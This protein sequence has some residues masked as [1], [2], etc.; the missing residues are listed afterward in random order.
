MKNRHK[1]FKIP[2]LGNRNNRPQ[3]EIQKGTRFWNEQVLTDPI[4]FFFL[5]VC[6][7]RCKP[8]NISRIKIIQSHTKL[9]KEPNKISN[10][11]KFNNKNQILNLISEFDNRFDTTE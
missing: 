7:K 1:P 5:F 8:E 6:F 2:C 4:C 11:K 10:T 9:E 3:K